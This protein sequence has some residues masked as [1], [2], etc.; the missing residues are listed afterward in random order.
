MYQAVG[1]CPHCAIK[2]GMS[3][4]AAGLMTPV[5]SYL[6]TSDI[7]ISHNI[8]FNCSLHV[9]NCS[10]Y[11]SRPCIYIVS[12]S[13]IV[14]GSYVITHCSVFIVLTCVLIVRGWPHSIL[15]LA[16]CVP[17]SCIELATSSRKFIAY[18]PFGAYRFCI[19]VFFLLVVRCFF[20]FVL[21]SVHFSLFL[22]FSFL[23]LT[24]IR[25]WKGVTWRVGSNPTCPIWL[26][27]CAKLSRP[28]APLTNCLPSELILKG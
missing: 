21:F 15:W 14:I 17:V 26:L 11:Q 2:N 22:C 8:S 18:R 13:L 12:W 25:K 3:A 16:L 23:F 7:I 27:P 6:P 19:S 28:Y 4:T 9:P 24:K 10:C 20:C 1:P 5:G